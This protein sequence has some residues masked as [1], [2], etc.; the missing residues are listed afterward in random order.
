MFPPRNKSVGVLV[1]KAFTNLRKAKGSKDGILDNH[2]RL[3]YHKDALIAAE[4]AKQNSSKP[5]QQ[6]DCILDRK[7]KQLFEDNLHILKCIVDAV[8]FCGKQNIALRGHRDDSSNTASNRGN[9]LAT[10]DLMAKSDKILHTHLE[11]GQQTSK[12]TS[13]T[14]QNEI[15]VLI[16]DFIRHHLTL[17]IKAGSPSP[18]FS[19]MA[20]EVTDTFGNQEILSLCLR[21][22]QTNDVN[23]VEIIEAF[24][25]YSF[26]KRTTGKAISES[27]LDILRANELN[28]DNLRGQAYDGA[29]A[30]SSEV[31][32]VNGRIRN[33]APKALYTHCNSHVLNLSIAASCK[34]TPVRNMIGS[35]NEIYLLFHN[36]PKR[37]RFFEQVLAKLK[38]ESTK[39]KLLG[40]CKTRWV[41]RH[42]CY[43]TFH[44]LYSELTTCLDAI[45]NPALYPDI[46]GEENWLWDANTRTTAQGLLTT[47]KSF[48]FIMA[49]LTIKSCLLSV[50]PIA[51]LLQCSDLDCY[52]AYNLI[53]QSVTDLK[54][55]RSNIDGI[56]KD[57]YGEAVKLS[58]DIGG[59]VTMSRVGG[60]FQQH[61]DNI[62]S[63]TTE[64]Y[65]RNSIAIPF[66]DHLI[67][68]MESRFSEDA[69]KCRHLFGL[70]PKLIVKTSDIELLHTDLQFWKTDL[71]TPLNLKS[72]LGSWKK[73]WTSIGNESSSTDSTNMSFQESV[74]QWS[75]NRKCSTD[76]VPDS[77]LQ[78]Y[79]ACNEAVFP[80]VKVLLAIA[81]VMPVGSASAERSFSALRRVKTFLRNTMGEDRLAGLALM[82]I[83]H[84]M[85]IDISEI[86]SM[87]LRKHRLRMFQESIM[88]I[89]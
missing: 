60:R 56:F 74:M 70:I 52:E 36:S 37:Q 24:F 66:L 86:I 20:D 39:K 43:D 5:S 71:P 38:C 40:L 16:G 13:K 34:M 6:V 88:A 46:Y 1:N 44:E 7:R 45:V 14:I 31:N 22:L 59:Y 9:F 47:I 78:S 89:V 11:R 30:M 4:I 21:F 12:Y 55:N 68:E 18:F 54:S 28:I 58:E 15:V 2:M 27:I 25:N 82:H 8:V 32:G 73:M 65:F 19:I 17:G 67:T 35:L 76:P 77:L 57:W 51:K 42:S 50:M 26:L 64:Q 29:S 62:P 23:N 3:D 72:E 79:R 85:K 61:R 87:F 83:H 41:E 53:G 33:V 63:S 75:R 81:C 49:F 84:S 80:N 48:P 69:C 10:L